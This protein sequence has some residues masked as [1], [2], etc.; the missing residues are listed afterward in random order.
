MRRIWACIAILA[1]AGFLVPGAPAVAGEDGYGRKGSVYSKPKQRKPT[2]EE[3]ARYFALYGGFIDPQLNKQ[4]PGGPF[5]SGFFFDS[6]I[7]RN[8]GDSPYMN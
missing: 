4:S 5:D 2:Q 6:G 3:I 1:V 8:G 7:T